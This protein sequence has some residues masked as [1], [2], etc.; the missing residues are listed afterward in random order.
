MNLELQQGSP[1]LRWVGGKSWMLKYIH[2]YLP[3][4]GFKSYHEPFLGGGAIF[5]NLK[6]KNAYLS[7]LNEELINT[8]KEIRDNVEGVI[9]ELKDFKNNKDYYY[10]IRDEK[11]FYN[12]S[13][14]AASFIYLNQTS[15]NGIYRVNLNSKYNVPYGFRT[16]D[17]FQPDNLRLASL[18]LQSANLFTADFKEIIYNIKEGDL[19]FLDPPYTVSHYNNG[20]IKYN[21]KLF[22]EEDQR[23]LSRFINEIKDLG[24]YYILTNA[25]HKQVHEI[26][27]INGDR[28]ETEERASLIGGKKAKRGIYK[29]AIFT[30]VLE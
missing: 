18:A 8:Y 2:K 23:K 10:F 26:F 1:F 3:K 16:K 14:K 17:F 7:D 21:S 28:R 20:F 30:N 15:F 6:P 25:D 27:Q 5:F 19:V 12:S 11:E 9:N 22:S 4:N 29:E 13:G 24:A